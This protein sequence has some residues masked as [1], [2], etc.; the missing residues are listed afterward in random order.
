[1]TAADDALLFGWDDALGDVA[2][3]VG[4]LLMA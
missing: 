3:D 2:D 4:L 1:M